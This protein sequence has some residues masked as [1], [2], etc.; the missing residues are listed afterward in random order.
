MECF[1]TDLVRPFYGMFWHKSNM[2]LPWNIL[3]INLVGILDGMFWPRSS[4]NLLW[5]VLAHLVKIFF[6]R[7][8][9]TSS[10]IGL[11]YGK[12]FDHPIE[13]NHLREFMETGHLTFCETRWTLSDN[14]IPS[15]S[16][17]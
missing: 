13:L 15:P 1:G 12:P 4:R 9:H 8:W 10:E 11:L 16:G 6:G 14:L 17:V 7:F 2:K 5:K 3:S